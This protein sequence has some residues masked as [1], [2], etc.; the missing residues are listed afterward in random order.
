MTDWFVYI[1]RCVDGSLYTGVTNDVDR[2]LKQHN[3]GLQGARY[4]RQRRPVSLV[5]CERVDGRAQAQRR[6]FEIKALAK[7]DKEALINSV[8]LPE[9]TP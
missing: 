6:E 8:L 4:T 7:T 5:Y 9:N 3:A 1:L 2:R